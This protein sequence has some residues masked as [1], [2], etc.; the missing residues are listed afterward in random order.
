LILQGIAR[1]AVQYCQIRDRRF[2]ATSFSLR[3]GLL[4]SQMERP[5]TQC[6]DDQAECL[7]QF[8]LRQPRD[9]AVAL[10]TR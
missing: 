7:G 4:D 6:T 10:D 3:T 1:F 8:C 5:V 9:A 2:P